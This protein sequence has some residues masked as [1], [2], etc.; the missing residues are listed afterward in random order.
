MQ[1][2]AADGLR[3]Q[4]FYQV[5]LTL[6]G[7]LSD[8]AKNYRLIPGMQV[9]A[10]IKVGERRIIEYLIDPLIKALDESLNEP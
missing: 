6:S 9:T 8:R 1:Q 2:Q 7:K 4:S 5:K 10:E 3:Q